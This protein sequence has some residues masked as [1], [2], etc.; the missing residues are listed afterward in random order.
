[1][2]IFLGIFAA[3]CLSLKG[4][5]LSYLEKAGVRL[6]LEF[7]GFLILPP[8]WILW[9]RSAYKTLGAMGSGQRTYSGVV[10]SWIVPIR[11][12]IR[13][14]QLTRDL[15]LRSST[16][17]P[18][19]VASSAAT[20]ALIIAWWCACLAPLLWFSQDF[21]SESLVT[22]ILDWTPLASSVLAALVVIRIQDFQLAQAGRP[23]RLSRLNGGILR[24]AAS[25][26]ALGAI[27]WVGLEVKAE[28]S[29]S[30]PE[31]SIQALADAY[32]HRDVEAFRRYCDSAAVLDQAY[33]RVKSN[34]DL[35]ATVGS[36]PNP[37]AFFVTLLGSVMGANYER[38]R[39]ETARQFEE[40]FVG[41]GGLPGLGPLLPP[42]LVK[43]IP[44]GGGPLGKI[45]IQFNEMFKAQAE[46]MRADFNSE[47]RGIVK[48]TREGGDALVELRYEKPWEKKVLDLHYTVRMKRSWLHWRVARIETS[49]AE[50]K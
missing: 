4:P 33:Q 17:N 21:L 15:W 39:E 45:G 44:G 19:V 25:A 16:G 30:S 43:S 31:G 18:S 12:L 48:V 46:R 49:R 1:L 50:L 10:R 14:F 8:L 6:T 29:A 5:W 23:E 24:L 40:S 41:G 22:T 34:P 13:P 35:A 32:N 27:A 28:W 36:L 47:Y 2:L 26:V 3:L 11:N 38:N 42:W 20:P 37:T 9:Q 7:L